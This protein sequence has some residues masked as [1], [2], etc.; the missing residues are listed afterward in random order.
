M[1]NA[2]ELSSSQNV[3]GKGQFKD[4]INVGIQKIGKIPH[5]SFYLRGTE[6]LQQDA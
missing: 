1:W 3:F 6:E 5:V 2:F 4:R